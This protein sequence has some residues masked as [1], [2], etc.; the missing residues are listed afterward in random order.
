MVDT[1]ENKQNPSKNIIRPNIVKKCIYLITILVIFS[2]TLSSIK[3]KS[4]EFIFIFFN[5]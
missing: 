5:G 4:F 1:Y 2:L 3:I